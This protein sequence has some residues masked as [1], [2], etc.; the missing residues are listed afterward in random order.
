VINNLISNAVKYAPQG[1]LIKVTVESADEH[2][3]IT[4]A[5]EGI[6]MT[7]EQVE[8]IF[9]H[10]YRADFSNSAVQ[11]VGLGMSIARHI[12][13]AHHGE[14]LV[15]SWPG[16]GTRVSVELPQRPPA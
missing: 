16:R 3:R 1:G 11:G 10:F 15:E 9:D 4:V 8:H 2:C 5:D 12:V 7:P 6:G 13:Q 14:I